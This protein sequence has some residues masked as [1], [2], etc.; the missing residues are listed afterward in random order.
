[1]RFTIKW[2]IDLDADNAEAAAGLAREIQLD[3]ESTATVFT[4]TTRLY[5]GDHQEQIDVQEIA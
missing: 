5:Q 4:V 1:M 2:E 3:P